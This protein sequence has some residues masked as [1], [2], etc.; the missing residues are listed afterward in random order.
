MFGFCA[1][2][3]AVRFPLHHDQASKSRSRMFLIV[4]TYLLHTTFRNTMVRC[5]QPIAIASSA[6]LERPALF[7]P[8]ISRRKEFQESF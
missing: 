6:L 4:G 1:I 2:G 7:V 3:Q 5:T 8:A